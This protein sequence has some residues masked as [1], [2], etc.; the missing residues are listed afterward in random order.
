MI[1]KKKKKQKISISLSLDVN[2]NISG[3]EHK[4][5]NFVS[6]EHIVEDI[7]S[8]LKKGHIDLLETLGEK[9]VDLCFEDER[10][11]TIKLK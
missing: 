4:I 7:K 2:D 1:L 3:I 6:Y 10:V 11:M 8:I 9:I 5:E